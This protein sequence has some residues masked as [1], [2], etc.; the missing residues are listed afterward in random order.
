MP[1][2]LPDR[3]EPG[4]LNVPGYAGLR[5]GLCYVRRMGPD[6]LLRR[7]QALLKTCIRGLKKL[8]WTQRML[9]RLVL[10]AW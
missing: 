10:A 6:T 2:E 7:E 3:L 9:C 5:E 4:T 8:P 1:P